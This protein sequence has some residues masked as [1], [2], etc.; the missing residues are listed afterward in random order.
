M[1]FLKSAM[2]PTFLLGMLIVAQSPAWSQ[3]PPA[4]SSGAP[5]DNTAVN[6]RD[7]QSGTIKSTDQPNNKTDIQLAASVRQAIINDRS[8][9]TSAHNV[10]LVAASGVV[11]LRGPVA[12]TAERTRVGDIV[13][14]VAG[15]TSVDNQLD[16]TNH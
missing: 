13:S 9:S 12:T 16:I 1:K 6:A 15:V 11:T 14:K 2:P 3:D 5:A 8:L 10:K 7:K 4:G